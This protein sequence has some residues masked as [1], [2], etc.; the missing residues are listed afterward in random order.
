[1]ADFTVVEGNLTKPVGPQGGE[2]IVPVKGVGRPMPVLP[3][4]MI[5][6]FI[7]VLL[8]HAR[9]NPDDC[10]KVTVIGCKGTGYKPA[11][12]APMFN[13]APYNVALPY[14]FIY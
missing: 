11:Q 6:Y 9:R 10:F 12:I 7:T 3:L 4:P 5:H 1:M 14:E 13:Y 2:W 8:D